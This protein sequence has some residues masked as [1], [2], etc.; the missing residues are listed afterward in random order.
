MSKKGRRPRADTPKP[1][2]DEGI[3]IQTEYE[4]FLKGYY[5]TVSLDKDI[6]RSLQPEEALRHA[7]A[8]LSAVARA[9]HDAAV[10]RQ[11]KEAF[12][13]RGVDE[14]EALQNIARVMQDIRGGRPELDVQGMDP[15]YLTPG[16]NT[17]F[18]PFLH[19]HEASDKPPI[20][21]Y[22]MDQARQHAHAALEMSTVA[23][24]DSAYLRV[25]KGVI[26]L[27]ENVGLNMISELQDHRE[28]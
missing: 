13:G 28:Y 4:P 11:L 8:V 16:V 5:V 10:C 23:D 19:V 2:S 17:K 12:D 7:S 6:I 27:P 9:E 18:E 25:L 3:W 24:L 14:N 20:G 26:G 15:I 21:Q 22:D 1:K